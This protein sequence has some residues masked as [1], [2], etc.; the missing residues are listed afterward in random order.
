MVAASEIQH[1][2]LKGELVFQDF[3]LKLVRKHWN[4]EY[5]EAFGRSGQNQRGV[6]IVGRDN[7]GG[8][9]HA[10]MQ[11]KASETDDP[12]QLTVSE[13]DEEVAKAKS[14]RPNLDILIV[15][16]AG[17]RD[18]KLQ[19]KAQE[20]TAE[21][22]AADLFRVV[23]WSWPD[24]VERSLNYPEVAQELLVRNGIPS[25]VSVLNPPRPLS[26]PLARLQAEVESAFDA[27]RASA[28]E[29]VGGGEMTAVD[30]KLDVFRDQI[31]AGNGPM[32]IDQL[33]ALLADVSPDTPGRIKLRIFG[34]LGAALVQVGDFQAAED[35]FDQAGESAS[36]TAGG[37]AYKAR[38]EIFRGQQQ[39]A[40]TL[41]QA[42]LD[43][44]AANV[45]AANV[46]IESAPTNVSSHELENRVAAILG[47][48]D[49]AGSLQRRYVEIEQDHDASLRIA[50]GIA[51]QD[52]RK[53]TIVAQAILSRYEQNKDA[54]VGA[55]LDVSD[56]FL[57]EEARS[58]F[59]RAWEQIRSRPDKGNWTFVAA[60]LIATMRLLGREQEAD[61]FAI[62]THMLLPDDPVLI[63]RCIFAHMHQG[64]VGR[65]LELAVG[66][67]S[68]EHPDG[69]AL[70]LAA[71][72]SASARDWSGAL[73]WAEKA[74]RGAGGDKSVIARA[75]ELRVVGVSRTQS[76][77]EALNLA[78]TLRAELS[79]IDISFES[80]VAEIAR[81]AG[82]DTTVA[83]IRKRLQSIDERTLDAV[84]RFELSDALAD[85]GEW[86]K[87]ADL[88]E[89]LY[90]PDRPSET[91]RRRLFYLYRADDRVAARALFASLG[92]KVIAMPDI[93]RLGA[94]IY[95][96]SGMLKQA[97][98]VLDKAVLLDP[99][100]LRSRLDWVRLAIRAGEEKRVSAWVKKAKLGFEGHRD[101]LIELA[102]ILDRYGRRKD[103]LRVGYAAL[104]ANWAKSE[105]THM[106]YL[107][108][109]LLHFEKD[110]FLNVRRVQQDTVVT[111]ES[112]L[113]ERVRYLIGTDSMPGRQVLDIDHPFAKGLL[114]KAAGDTLDLQGIGQPVS[115]KVVDLLHKYVDLF[116]EALDAHSRLYPNSRALG[117][118]TIDTDRV[119]GLEPI[120]EQARERHRL[121]ND[122]VKIYN[123]NPIPL[124]LIAKI[125]GSDSV[126]VSKGLR[127]QSE[128]RFDSCLGDHTERQLALQCLDGSASFL[129]DT[130]TL[131]LWQEIGF[132]EIV[133]TLPVKIHVVQATIDELAQ[134][135][136]DA[137]NA[138]NQ[139]G[140]SLEARGDR[141]VMIEPTAEQ[142]RA[143]WTT[144]EELLTWARTNAELLPT[145]PLKEPRTDVDDM[146]SSSAV[147]TIAT[148]VE[149]G[150]P[151]VMED[152]RLR[153]LA[154]EFG[155]KRSAWTQPFL[156]IL[157][158]SRLLANS[159]YVRL[160]ASLRKCRVGF[161][162]VGASDL[163]D[164]QA[165]GDAEFT[166]L[167]G[168]LT[169]ADVDPSSV[170]TVASE[171]GAV[172]WRDHSFIDRRESL[173]SGILT[174]LL[175][176]PDGLNIMVRIARTIYE[177]FVNES[178]EEYWIGRMWDVYFDGYLRGHFI[179]NLVISR[180]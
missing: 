106:G 15:A 73:A 25:T 56:E 129:V 21:H 35:A 92:G 126:D 11:C 68:G 58:A 124:D 120:F 161:V 20:I 167:A 83:E 102:Q 78:A 29:E 130:L 154:A 97:L 24:I 16:Y 117:K 132:L 162:S 100:D 131:A 151:L 164:A 95:E 168:A 147:D 84:G 65:A 156:T 14:Y 105:R 80:R 74:Y 9:K 170:V 27:F 178:I 139:R 39:K 121:V 6:D 173:F 107:S 158:K 94:A 4:D 60:N 42:A 145:S 2:R 54:K 111:L 119:E 85:D 46:F 8:Y 157:R 52:W 148:A 48:V 101:E 138:L 10:A 28:S 77:T 33:R 159:D 51:I 176:R 5:A 17:E 37:L 91:L 19:Q 177:N 96:K 12:R 70:I 174:N 153:M 115:W 38:A 59:L 133:E 43:L 61:E 103:A 125:L 89:G 144:N 72:V 23:V 69:E 180:R 88:L 140:G 82:D 30:A 123:E 32:V 34:N 67:A 136:D 179:R 163:V 98:E 57:L 90:Q 113:G 44:E 137:R 155:T 134:R 128:I 31:R 66:L 143:W 62:A 152:R 22:D 55:P 40:F 45:S 86:S 3:C 47:E 110:R 26:N 150:L 146:L 64:D 112:N 99:A 149:T 171:L 141:F 1:T 118:F 116:R 75:A 165:I 135:E 63:Q 76:P 49:V 81:R 36:E 53:D 71:S 114:G 166:T 13:L 142:R 41:A 109:F 104:V 175:R 79:A 108:L 160:L 127:F 93:L 7:R 18:V 87:A 122:A 169:D 172:L 50:R